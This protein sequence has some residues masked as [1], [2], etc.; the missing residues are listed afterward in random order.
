MDN[1]THRTRAPACLMFA[2]ICLTTM[3]TNSAAATQPTAATTIGDTTAS[4][5]TDYIQQQASASRI[6]GMAV[7]IVQDSHPLLLNAFGNDGRC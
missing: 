1:Q 6:P 3:L 2:V 5:I 7:G 4:R